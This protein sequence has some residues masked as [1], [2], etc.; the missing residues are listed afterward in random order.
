MPR[1]EIKLINKL[2]MNGFTVECFMTE[3]VHAAELAT[4]VGACK[5]VTVQE[6]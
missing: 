3:V 4:E 6:N 5:A 1:V 2:I